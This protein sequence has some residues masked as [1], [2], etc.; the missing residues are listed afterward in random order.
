[1]WWIVTAK[2]TSHNILQH[3]AYFQTRAMITES[4][5]CDFSAV[6]LHVTSLDGAMHHLS[7]IERRKIVRYSYEAIFVGFEVHARVAVK[8]FY[9]LTPSGQV[10]VFTCLLGFVS[11][12]IELFF[13]FCFVCLFLW[14]WIC[15]YVALQ[16]FHLVRWSW[17]QEQ[18][19][20]LAKSSCLFGAGSWK[21]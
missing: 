1:M 10:K 20:D 2:W 17:I 7:T 18:T 4:C 11:Q 16:A 21:Q 3:F 13:F 8:T 14:K 12:K 5:L 19:W 6:V 15:R 9:L